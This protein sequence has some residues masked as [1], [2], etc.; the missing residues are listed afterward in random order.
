MEELINGIL[1]KVSSYDIFNNFFPGIIFCYILRKTTR[2]FLADGEIWENIF[3]YY[4]VGIIINRIGSIVVERTLRAIKVKN[5][6]K[7]I[8][9]PFLKFTEYDNYIK[10]SEE[11]PF[12]K[13]L[14]ETNNVYRTIISMFIVIIVIKLYDSFLYDFINS[15]GK[16]GHDFIFITVCLLVIILFLYSYKKQTEYINSRIEKYYDLKRRCNKVNNF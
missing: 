2:F 15:F 5:K 16:V 3:I 4:F 14:N 10:T 1:E 7:N 13:T 12:I 9:E 11:E 6:E 8:K